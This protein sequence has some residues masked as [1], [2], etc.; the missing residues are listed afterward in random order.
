V[1]LGKCRECGVEVS[2]EAKT[3]P[4]CGIK[5]PIR[6]TRWIRFSIIGILGGLWMIG[7]IVSKETANLSTASGSSSAY[8]SAESAKTPLV[9][10]IRAL[11]NAYKANEVS[12]DA[13]YK[14]RLVQT[15]GV[16]SKVAKDILD[17][18]YVTL[19]TGAR[20]EIP[21]VQCFFSDS[22]ASAVGQLRPGQQITVQGRVHGKMMNVI[23]RDCA[24]AQ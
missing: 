5:T 12:A 7:A 19:G 11:L 20:F 17:K 18:I 8:E 23:V 10:P 15:T 22:D 24:L 14:K 4:K 21:E 9:V 16:V 1:A 13:Q 3:C 6:T 2:S